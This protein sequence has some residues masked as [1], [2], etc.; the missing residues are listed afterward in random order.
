MHHSTLNEFFTI[1]FVSTYIAEVVAGYMVAIFVPIGFRSP[2]FLAIPLL[3]FLLALLHVCL[4][5]TVFS[6]HKIDPPIHNC[7]IVRAL[8]GSIF[9]VFSIGAHEYDRTHIL[10]VKGLGNMTLPVLICVFICMI[11]FYH[12]ALSYF[13]E[14]QALGSLGMFHDYLVSWLPTHTD[15]PETL[16]EPLSDSFTELRLRR[17][18]SN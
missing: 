4:V 5:Q 18:A 3:S 1:Y 13:V 17:D 16:P 8:M 2:F 14:A 12:W 15:T 6:A 7:L 11:F 9:V 10:P